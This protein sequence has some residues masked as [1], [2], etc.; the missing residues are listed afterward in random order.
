MAKGYMKRH[1]MSQ[2]IR[3]IHIKA[4]M[5]YHLT[6]IRMAIMK[7]LRDNKYL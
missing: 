1:S 4:T 7:M 3:E 2:N 6:P 5:K